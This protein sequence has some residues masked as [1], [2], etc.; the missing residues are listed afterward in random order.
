[1][2]PKY[3][4]VTRSVPTMNSLRSRPNLGFDCG[5]RRVLQRFHAQQRSTIK[6]IFVQCYPKV[7]HVFKSRLNSSKQTQADA[8]AHATDA[9]SIHH[10]IRNHRNYRKNVKD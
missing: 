10:A 2:S 9:L 6:P 5:K 7:C 3:N 4:H 8:V 1:M